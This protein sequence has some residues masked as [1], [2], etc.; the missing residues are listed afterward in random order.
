MKSKI[1]ILLFLVVTTVVGTLVVHYV[2][3]PQ[4]CMRLG[5]KNIEYFLVPSVDGKECKV[6]SGTEKFQKILD[7]GDYDPVTIAPKSF[8]K[9][10]Y[11]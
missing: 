5:S 10:M 11:K 8:T 2:D 9:E 3:R 6:F 4:G 7:S 1:I